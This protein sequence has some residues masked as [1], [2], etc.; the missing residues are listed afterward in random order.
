MAAS[1]LCPSFHLL[2]LNPYHVVCCAVREYPYLVAL[3]P[4]RL[5]GASP[6]CMTH[7]VLAAMVVSEVLQTNCYFFKFTQCQWMVLPS[8]KVG[9]LIQQTVCFH[10]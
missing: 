7:A 2:Q 4:N 1:P 5:S 9:A 3:L 8:S 6:L 10:P